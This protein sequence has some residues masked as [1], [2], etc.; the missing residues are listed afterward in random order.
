MYSYCYVY[1][2]LLTSMLCSVYSLQT[3]IFRLP[4]LRFS[5]AFSSVL[6]QMPG[7]TSQRRGTV[8]TL[9]NQWI[10]LFCLLFYVDCCSV[11]CL[12]VNVYCHRVA[13]QLQ[14]IYIYISYHISS[15]HIAYHIYHI[16]YHGVSYHI[17]AYHIISYIISLKKM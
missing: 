11:Y 4:C 17:K 10:V 13:T 1:V 5:R 7:Y 14:L 6:R 3:G 8:R 15:Y 9:P 12:C 16:I 2:F